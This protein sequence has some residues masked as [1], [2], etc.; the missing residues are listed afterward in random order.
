MFGCE[1]KL[2][3]IIPAVKISICY[4]LVEVG[5]NQSEIANML[6]ITQPL[7]SKYIN[8]KYSVEL[9]NLVSK[10]NKNNY[11][12]EKIN[13]SLELRKNENFNEIILNIISDS[14]FIKNIH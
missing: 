3:L 5:F 6:G 4:K 9:Q 12:S 14:N 11:T 7:V 8:G 13:N 1:D 2:K 10:I